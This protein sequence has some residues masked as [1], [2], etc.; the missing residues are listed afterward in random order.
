MASSEDLDS[1]TQSSSMELLKSVSSDL[2]RIAKT[3]SFSDED[4]EFSPSNDL[5]LLSDLR[6]G[7]I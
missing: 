7:L 3:V 6:L 5:T 2:Q 4:L 1:P